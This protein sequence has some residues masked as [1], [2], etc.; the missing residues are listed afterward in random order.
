MIGR[1]LFLVGAASG[2]GGC[3]FHPL[4]GRLGASGGAVAP[5]LASIYVTVMAE[6]QGQLLRQALQ[7]RL[8]GTDDSG[9]KVYELSG[10]LNIAAE[11]IGIQQ[12]SSSTRLRFNGSSN[13]TLK[14][15]DLA[16]TIVTTGTARATDG[17]NINNQEYFAADLETSAAY[18]RLA[19]T[20]ADQIT[21]DLAIYFRTHPTPA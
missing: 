17:I 14:K 12:D 16:N 13:W 9:T 19:D 11:A 4:Y 20:V 15:L 21:Q 8:A 3:G 18:R 1:R 10:G 7:Q 5:E 6:R 2:L